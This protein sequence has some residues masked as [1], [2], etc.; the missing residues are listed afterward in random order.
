MMLSEVEPSLNT[1]EIWF[2]PAGTAPMKTRRPFIVSPLAM[3]MYG[4]PSG[5]FRR[6]FWPLGSSI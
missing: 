3:V 4:L 5:G 1:T 2:T 6:S